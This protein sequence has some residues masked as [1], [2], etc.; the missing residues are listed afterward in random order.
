MRVPSERY[1]FAV[2]FVL[3]LRVSRYAPIPL[4]WVPID[5]SIFPAVYAHRPSLL[6][7]KG[8]GMKIKKMSLFTY[9]RSMSSLDVSLTP[10]SLYFAD[11]LLQ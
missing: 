10:L 3:M 2:S 5:L 1:P 9:R 11:N 4:A 6:P 8:L 7:I